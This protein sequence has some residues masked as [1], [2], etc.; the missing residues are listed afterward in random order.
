[1]ADLTAVVGVL[2]SLRNAVELT[3][4]F[5]KVRDATMKGKVAD[6]QGE[7]YTARASALSAQATQAELI[8]E[9]ASMKKQIAEFSTWEGE[10]QRYQLKEIAPGAF[11]YVLKPDAGGGQPPHWICA[12]CYQHRHTSILQ[13]AGQT[14][15]ATTYTCPQ[16]A[17][18]IRVAKPANGPSG[19]GLSR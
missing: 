8:D 10:K 3:K 1:M 14:H 17:A 7:I 4:D 18:S 9:I 5:L 11:A 12:N 6:L 16:C 2:T 15:W 13:G 19:P